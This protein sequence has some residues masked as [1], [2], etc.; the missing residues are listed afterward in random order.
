[1]ATGTEAAKVLLN[2]LLNS[3]L[4][5]E[6]LKRVQK[7]IDEYA[8]RGLRSLA[9]AFQGGISILSL[10]IFREGNCCAEKLANHGHEI[11][12]VFWWDSLP[13]FLRED[14]FRDRF[15]LPNYRFL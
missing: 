1:M 14:F 5:G 12:N 8:E 2:K 11:A 9:V 6:T 10:H 4:K 7:T 15:G 3:E 13:S